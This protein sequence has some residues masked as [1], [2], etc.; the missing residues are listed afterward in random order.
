MNEIL[1]LFLVG[2][3]IVLLLLSKAGSSLYYCRK[4]PDVFEQAS[5]CSIKL[6]IGITIPIYWAS[7]TCVLFI[8]L[9]QLGPQCL[10]IIF[11]SVLFTDAPAPAVFGTVIVPLTC[12]Y[13]LLY[14]YKFD[15]IIDALN[16]LLSY[17]PRDSSFISTQFLVLNVDG[18]FVVSPNKFITFDIQLL[19]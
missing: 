3:S 15:L 17:V 4:L 9:M 18:W 8:S 12:I 7:S 16:L 14:S 5:L 11:L 19:Y 1:L 13:A 2:Q 10:N 6:Y